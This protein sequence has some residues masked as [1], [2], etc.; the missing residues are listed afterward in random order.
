MRLIILHIVFLFAL[1]FQLNAQNLIP[2]Y[3]FEQK[4]SCGDGWRGIDLLCKDWFTPMLYLDT[5]YN[6]NTPNN[7]GNSDYFN[8]CNNQLFNVPNNL[9]GYQ[10]AK[11]GVAYAGFGL[12]S[13]KHP[14][15]YP[16]KN[17]KEYI[18]VQLISKLIKN[19]KYCVEFY[20][21]I[22]EKT[23]NY[24]PIAI[25]AIITDT[26]V[27]RT[28]HPLFYFTEIRASAQISDNL[29][30]NINT[31]DWIKVSGSFIA[32]GGEQYLTI[33]NFDNTDHINNPPS[34]FTAIGI[35]VYVDDVKLWYCDE[36]TTQEVDEM[37]I[38]NVFTP[39][40]DGYNDKFIYKNQEQW[41]FETRI[42]NRW[43]VPVFDNKSSKNWD[44]TFEGVKVSAGVYFYIIRAVS[45]KNGEIKIYQGSIT[46]I[47]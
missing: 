35:Y 8:T 14:P 12:L 28:P 43:E 27:K 40:G 44:A 17:H 22:S 31:T 32:K 38:P 37:I 47:Y 26:L 19:R 10:F 33:G 25:E 4:D 23:L 18:E 36:D 41:E 16:Y 5:A 6:P 9:F 21:S 24:H 11:I 46:V 1:S 15:N 39:N 34:P 29:P 2:N 42:F 30:T 13:V 3:S 7:Y 45:T 20:Y